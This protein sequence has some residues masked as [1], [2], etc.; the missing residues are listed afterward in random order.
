MVLQVA[1]SIL[2]LILNVLS[3]FE[4]PIVSSVALTQCRTLKI[5][6]MIVCSIGE[7]WMSA[8]SLVYTQELRYRS[9]LDTINAIKTG[10][11]PQ[12]IMHYLYYYNNIG[13]AQKARLHINLLTPISCRVSYIIYVSYVNQGLYYIY[14]IIFLKE[15][16]Y[17]IMIVPA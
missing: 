12:E 15:N 2:K 10:S 7:T 11:Y 8:C 17:S 4:S 6:Y 1:A 3:D 13:R 16:V 5:G 14:Y 9:V